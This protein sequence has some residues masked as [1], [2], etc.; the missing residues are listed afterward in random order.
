MEESAEQAPQLPAIIGDE[1]GPQAFEERT[2][3]SREDGRFD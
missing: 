1:I 2:W 3:V